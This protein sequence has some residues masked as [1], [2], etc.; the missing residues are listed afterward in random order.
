MIFFDPNEPGWFS[1]S[2][3]L[4]DADTFLTAGHCTFGIG[5]DMRSPDRPWWHSGRPWTP[6]LGIVTAILAVTTVAVVEVG[7]LANLLKLAPFPR[8]W[9]PAVV[10]VAVVAT[11]WSEP[12]KRIAVHR[13]RRRH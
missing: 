12:L 10:A 6:T 13:R 9:W 4:L 8:E 11:T 3:T 7:P 1:C 5:T 2:G